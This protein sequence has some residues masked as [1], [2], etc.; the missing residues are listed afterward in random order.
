L[1]DRNSG[2]L[3]PIEVPFDDTSKDG[4]IYP[5]SQIAGRFIEAICQGGKVTPNLAH[6]ARV[7]TLIDAVRLAHRKGSWQAVGSG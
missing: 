6:G 7:Q 4:R 1:G 2:K 5:V 3:L